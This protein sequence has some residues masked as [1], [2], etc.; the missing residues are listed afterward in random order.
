M[1][2][3]GTAVNPS[4]EA[5]GAPSMARTLPKTRIPHH[6]LLGGVPFM[7]MA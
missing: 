1:R 6:A 2:V 5:A 7:K 3:L 4:M